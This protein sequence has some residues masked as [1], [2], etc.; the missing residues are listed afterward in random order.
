MGLLQETNVSLW[1]ATAGEDAG[2]DAA[3]DPARSFDVA[4][5]GAGIAGLSAALAVAESGGSVVVLEAGQVC[6]GVTAYTTA[7]V[8]SLHGLK[9][10]ALARA[11]GEEAAR[12]YGDAN[13]AA[14]AQVAEWVERHGIDCDFSRRAA[15]TYTTSSQAVKSIA[16]EVETAQKLGLPGSFTTETELPFEVTGAVRFDQQAQFH[17]RQYCLG[18]ARA[19]VAL[20]GRVHEG[21]RATDVSEGSPCTVRTSAGEVR[22][23]HVVLATHLPFLD[24]GGFFA[25]CEPTRSYAL[26]A[27]LEGPV[28]TGMYL[29]ADTPTRSVRAAMGDTVVVLGGEGHKVGQDDDTRA[30]YDALEGWARDSFPLR[31]IEH[32]WSAQDHT[33][34]DGLP[35]VGRQAKGSRVLVATGFDKWGM[36]NGTAAAVVLADEIAGR[37][38]R[39]AGLF[40][41]TRQR[42]PLTSR[43]LYRANANVARQFVGDRLA[44][45]RPP[46][47][48]SLEPGT[49]GIVTLDG[50]K[51][52]AFRDDDGALHAVSPVCTHLGCL[53]AFNTAER[54]WDCP[55]HG[56]RFTVDG[57]VIEGPATTDLARKEPG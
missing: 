26:A 50:D 52:A 47:A 51:V 46:P 57:A 7:K 19:V 40:D 8:S 55:C 24:R 31:S 3:V 30:R 1:A 17:P 29:S 41:A 48:D 36:T 37:A 13:E 10:A 21:V 33:P 54:S 43:D 49:G 15:Y 39:W 20:G 6:S 38:N 5:V 34:V 25:K 56:S 22:A 35:F 45:L 12:L 4:V 16:E 32:R 9:Y 18:L 42:D 11:Q 53:V 23:D 44:S 28:P 2:Y 14:I 27:R